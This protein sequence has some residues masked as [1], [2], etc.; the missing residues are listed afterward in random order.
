MHDIALRIV[1]SS[2]EVSRL[3]QV[4]RLPHQE[5]YLAPWL[6]RSA[7]YVHVCDSFIN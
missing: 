7:S 3:L 2:M 5:E 4:E 6:S 1:Q